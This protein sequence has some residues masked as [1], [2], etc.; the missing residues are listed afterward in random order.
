MNLRQQLAEI[1]KKVVKY[2]IDSFSEI[3][4]TEN[5][6]KIYF[7][8][9]TKS[10]F[11]VDY[12]GVGAYF[13]NLD[14][15]IIYECSG[16]YYK[17]NEIDLVPIGQI[18]LPESKADRV[19]LITIDIQPTWNV[20]LKSKY[21]N[22]STGLI[23]TYAMHQG[24]VNWRITEQPKL[25]VIYV[26]DVYNYMWNA[27]EGIMSKITGKKLDFILID[28][29]YG[30]EGSYSPIATYYTECAGN[31]IIDTNEGGAI[32]LVRINDDDSTIIAGDGADIPISEKTIFIHPTT[33]QRYLFNGTTMV[34]Y[35]D[36][37]GVVP[38]WLK[39]EALLTQS[40]EN[41]PVARVL[42]QDEKDYLG[43]VNYIYDVP[44]DY[45][46]SNSKL[47][48]NL[49]TVDITNIMY[50]Y[51]KSKIWNGNQFLISG[52]GGDGV[53]ENAFIEVKHKVRG[54]PPKLISAVTNTSGDKV[55]LTFDKKITNVDCTDASMFELYDGEYLN[56][57]DGHLEDGKI[58]ISVT[59]Y[60]GNPIQHGAECYFYYNNSFFIAESLDLGILQHFTN[61]PITNNVPAPLQLLNAFVV[62]DGSL[63]TL[64]FNNVMDSASVGANRF[65]LVDIYD[66]DTLFSSIILADINNIKDNKITFNVSVNITKLT[67]TYYAKLSNMYSEY[68]SIYGQVLENFNDY[69]VNIDNS[70]DYN[71]YGDYIGTL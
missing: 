65:G 62:I 14:T 67:P 48:L 1:P 30:P 36:V 56:D 38:K 19:Q 23:H 68:K 22:A 60:G 28:E 17:W 33:F 6:N 29:W 35:D 8:S 13:N 3:T 41:A 32:Q 31:I 12:S 10:I 42:N 54:N 63:L 58:I 64:E 57:V 24:S 21:F 27:D 59:A 49:S 40:G 15:S 55:I 47:K 46:G 52:G 5:K 44:G 2:H 16:N 25:G 66:Q 50:N 43:N 9:E 45:Y 61:F 4:G 20:P 69:P 34:E 71:I 51:I 26:F 18:D 70:I 39:Y 37:D 53:L 11:K 7:N